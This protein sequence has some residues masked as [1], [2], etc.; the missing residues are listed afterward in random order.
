MHVVTA[1]R[2]GFHQFT[3][4]SRRP[5][6]GWKWTRGQHANL[7]LRLKLRVRCWRRK[8]RLMPLFSPVFSSSD[9]CDGHTLLQIKTGLLAR[10]GFSDHLRFADALSLKPNPR[11]SDV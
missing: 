10:N 9:R 6:V 5:M 4:G 11:V 2:C 1:L 7:E 3:N 8:V